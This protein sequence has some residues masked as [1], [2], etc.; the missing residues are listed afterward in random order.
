MSNNQFY[1]FYITTLNGVFI[2]NNNVISIIV[3]VA[4]R[5][6]NVDEKKTK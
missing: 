3:N 4:F 6:Q 2:L 1:M 5:S